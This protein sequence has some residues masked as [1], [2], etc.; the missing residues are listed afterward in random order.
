MLTKLLCGLAAIAALAP[1]ADWT[2]TFAV[3][4]MPELRVETNDAAVRVRAGEGGRIFARVTVRGW[5]IGNGGVEITDYQSGNRV[6][7]RVHVPKWNFGFGIRRSV[8]VELDVPRE[9][10][11]DIQTGDGS[12]VVDGVAGSS[13]LVTGDGSIDAT[14][15]GALEARTGDGRVVARGRFDRVSIDTNDGSVEAEIRPGSRLNGSWRVR[16]AD[17][18]VRIRLPEGLAA[19]LDLTTGDGDIS[20]GL[21]LAL[22][23]IKSRSNIHGRLNGG[24]PPFLIRTGDGSIHVGRL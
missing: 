11:T 5:Q 14:L 2:K 18:S 16:T 24:G 23:G 9:I 15:D 8:L 17:G 19:D 12:I 6:D 3:S 20:I 22:S 1:A 7:L 13:R 4:G 21:P 10:A